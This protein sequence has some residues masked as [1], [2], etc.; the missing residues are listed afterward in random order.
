MRRGF[1]PRG[2]VAAGALLA[3]ASTGGAAL[4]VEKRLRGRPQCI[5]T[6]K[7]RG[8]MYR[9]M[10]SWINPDTIQQM[11]QRVSGQGVQISRTGNVEDFDGEGETGWPASFKDS[12]CFKGPEDEGHYVYVS[13]HASHGR[14]APAALGIDGVL[15]PVFG[16]YENEILVRDDDD[17]ICH[18]VA[19]CAWLKS[20]G[21]SNFGLY[22]NPRQERQGL[23]AHH[24]LT[25]N[26]ITVLKLY[27]DLITSGA[28]DEA[29]HD[30][31][32]YLVCEEYGGG[33]DDASCSR[34]WRL[35]TAAEPHPAFNGRTDLGYPHGIL[36]LPAHLARQELEQYVHRFHN[37]NLP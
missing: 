5:L 12:I 34:A 36:S 32:Y 28:F 15:S 13:P 23:T 2:L 3:L 29:L 20:H 37:C 25:R 7:F 10:W 4:E 14:I 21:N 8:D 17:G 26:Y 6:A 9:H 31:F 22:S 11:L 1:F 30:H 24:M 18:G 27:H 33:R 16:S 19:M 35:G